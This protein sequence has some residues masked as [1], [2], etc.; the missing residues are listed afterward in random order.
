MTVP[1]GLIL[2]LGQV[3]LDVKLRIVL[4]HG[5]L[6]I[7]KGELIQVLKMKVRGGMDALGGQGA[8][9]ATLCHQ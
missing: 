2:A 1:K 5:D 6:S 9:Q 7:R 3:H 8:F 4:R